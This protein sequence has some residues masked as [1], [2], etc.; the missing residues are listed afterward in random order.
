MSPIS[1]VALV[2]K[3]LL[4]S[5][6]L[7]QLLKAGF[8]VTVLSR[9]PSTSKEA[10]TGA[11]IIQADYSSAEALAPSLR[12][13]DAVVATVTTAAVLVQEVLIDASILAGVKHFIPS[14]FGLLNFDPDAQSLPIYKP[15]VQIQNYLK[16]KAKLGQISYTFFATGPFL[17]YAIGAPL[18]VDF[19]SRSVQLYGDGQQALSATSVSGIGKAIAGA[20]QKP[21]EVRNRLLRIHETVLTQR[22]IV[23]F[24]KKA[25]PAD[26]EWSETRVDPQEA[27]RKALVGFEENP[28]DPLRALELIKSAALSGNW[29]TEYSDA[30][31]E[32]VGL[33]QL[34]DAEVEE[35][36]AALF[37]WKP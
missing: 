11:P 4:G 21:D 31:N 2:G 26:A 20:L 1:K 12:G 32:L 6:V 3:G 14:D 27:L 15:F 34:S 28:A 16:E 9:N 24:A 13:F 22:K 7:D 37:S 30:D 25:A 36:S 19:H 18:F 35:R 5:A 10:T 8:D 29:Q 33:E 17:E 23:Q